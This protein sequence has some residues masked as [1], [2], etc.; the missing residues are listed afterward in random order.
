MRA[1]VTVA[2][3]LAVLAASPLASAQWCDE[4]VLF[5][6]S[7]G[8]IEITHLQSL[9]NCCCTV[10]CDVIQ[11]GF[12]IDVHEYE[13]LIMGGCDCLCCFDVEVEIGGLEPGI[14]TVSIIKHTEFGGVELVGS[15]PVMVTGTGPAFLRTA[16]L[17]CNETGLP[18]ETTW[19]VIKALYR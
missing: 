8:T 17:P 15:W 19:G 9:Y 5:D 10:E 1:A 16:Y 4:E 11:D 7:P 13:R 2:A 14:Y 18:D 6:T 12:W 3:L